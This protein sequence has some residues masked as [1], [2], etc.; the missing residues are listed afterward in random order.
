MAELKTKP[1]DANVEAF[2][3]AITDDK[4]R[5][6]AFALLGLMQKATGE[7]PRMWGDAIIGFG[8][9]H[10]VY[11]SGREGD[12]P[13]VGFSPRKQNLT[14]YIMAGFEPFADVLARL[15]KFKTGKGCLYL[16]RLSDVDAGVLEELV[17]KSVKWLREKG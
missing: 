10:Y 4:K 17:V 2:L 15:G 7:A 14:V 16:N 6:D 5:S 12:W 8:T 3:S 9:Y 13:P 11:A 1:T